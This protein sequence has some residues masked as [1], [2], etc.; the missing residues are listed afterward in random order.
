MDSSRF[1]VAVNHDLMVCWTYVIDKDAGSVL[2][3]AVFHGALLAQPGP[4]EEL[5]PGGEAAFILEL[6]YAMKLAAIKELAASPEDAP[7][8][9]DAGHSELA[10]MAEQA[11]LAK[12]APF[13]EAAVVSERTQLA[14][15]A[16]TSKAAPVPEMCAVAE[17]AIVWE[18]DIVRTVKV[19]VRPVSFRAMKVSVCI[20]LEQIKVFL[21]ENIHK[22]PPI[23]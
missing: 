22:I 15:L 21:H 5:A 6:A 11:F 19:Y 3:L 7:F 2:H 18:Q 14:K 4:T 12:C 8:A 9:K 1:R 10:A 16:P 20:S 13:S 17:L 23:F